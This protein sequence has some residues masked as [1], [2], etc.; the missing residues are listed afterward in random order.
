MEFKKSNPILFYLSGFAAF[1]ITMMGGW[2]LYLLSILGEKLEEVG[3]NSETNIEKLIKWE[4]STFVILL[5]IIITSYI[6]LA[7]KDQKKSKSI[8]AFFAGLTHELKTPLA[9]IR[10]QTESIQ[11]K[12]KGTDLNQLTN[13][14]IEDTIKLEMQMDKI[15]QLSRI[16]KGGN[17]NLKY[18]S[19]KRLLE[20]CVKDYDHQLTVN[21]ETFNENLE[22]YAD[23]FAL[24]LIFKNL[25][26]NSKVHTNS[27][28]V[29]IIINEVASHTIIKYYDEGD[30]HGNIKKL[31]Q[32]F[33]KYNSSTGSGIG[34]YLSKKLTQQMKGSFK[35][36]INQ[37]LIFDIHLQRKRYF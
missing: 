8:H 20:N 27:Q 15:L 5:L 13:R 35:I 30:F 14:L 37:G 7:L 29:Y 34:L 6:V 32:L 9:S 26:E 4:G 22:V 24:Q 1:I 17:L 11:N 10:L 3:G 18:L 23:E 28:N 36:S 21:I 2:W 16:E 31:G 33:Y 12:I 19:L 25:L